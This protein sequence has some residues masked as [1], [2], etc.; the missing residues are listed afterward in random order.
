MREIAL[1][2]LDIFYNSLQADSSLIKISIEVDTKK[3]LMEI[4]IIDNG[5]GM[6]K[7]FVNNVL[8]PFTTTR[9]TRNVGLGLSLF[10]ASTNRCEGDLTIWSKE[11]VGT[12]V[13]AWYKYSHIDRQPLGNMRDT[14]YIMILT[15]GENDLIYSMKKDNQSFVLDTRKIREE[16]GDDSPLTSPKIMGEI[17]MLLEEEEKKI[18]IS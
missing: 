10:K 11:K 14:V 17:K 1:H 12:I 6:K 8:D 4:K 9:T 2:I 5:K 3:D 16:I 18:N 7:E 15:L 13:K